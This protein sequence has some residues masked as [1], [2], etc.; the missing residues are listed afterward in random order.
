MYKAQHMNI[1]QHLFQER[2]LVSPLIYIQIEN[3][4]EQ[5]NKK[6]KIKVNYLSKYWIDN[7]L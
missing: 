1:K 7:Y 4:F 6:F 5:N 2:S 3:S